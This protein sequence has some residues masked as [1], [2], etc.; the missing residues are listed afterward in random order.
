MEFTVS[1]RPELMMEPV[2]LLVGAAI[3]AVSLIFFFMLCKY[4]IRHRKRSK[5]AA[6][7][8]KKIGAAFA[9]E[10]ALHSIDNIIQ[11]LSHSRIDIRESYQRLSMIMRIFVTDISGRDVTSLTLSE[12]KSS[13]LKKLAKLIEKWYAPEFAMKTRAD[14]INDAKQAKNVVETWN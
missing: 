8:P 10:K 1:R 13:D 9:R 5:K 7:P 2:W 4:R 6:R 11:D 14:F 3:L 12:L